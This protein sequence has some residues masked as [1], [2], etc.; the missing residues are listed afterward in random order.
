MLR[1]LVSNDYLQT[2][3]RFIKISPRTLL[4]HDFCH[5]VFQLARANNVDLFA[6]VQLAGGFEDIEAVIPP[7]VR[8]VHPQVISLA[9]GVTIDA[10]S[11]LRQVKNLD[12]PDFY[13]TGA[14]PEVSPHGSRA[15]FGHEPQTYTDRRAEIAQLFSLKGVYATAAYA[16]QYAG[17][18]FI[19]A[20]ISRHGGNYLTAQRVEKIGI[21]ISEAM[22]KGCDVIVV[23]NS[24]A[25]ATDPVTA[26]HSF[27]DAILTSLSHEPPLDYA[28]PTPVP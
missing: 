6:D 8:R 21:S 9:P 17:I 15:E 16:R 11:Y 23:G 12:S 25:Q 5:D 14:L 4:D 18:E 27:G 1:D 19:G 24:I 10:L 20:G 26:L 13:L 22:Q 28:K 2:F 7:L 3:I